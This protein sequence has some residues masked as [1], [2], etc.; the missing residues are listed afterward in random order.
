MI[1]GRI[2]LFPPH[3]SGR[4]QNSVQQVFASNWIAPLGPQV[5]SVLYDALATM[6][7]LM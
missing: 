3:L 1:T 4:E 5:G 6:G 2:F 7:E